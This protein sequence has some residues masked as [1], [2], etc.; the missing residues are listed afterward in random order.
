MLDD[1]IHRVNMFINTNWSA[2]VVMV[3]KTVSAIMKVR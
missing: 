2:A 1:L 3:M